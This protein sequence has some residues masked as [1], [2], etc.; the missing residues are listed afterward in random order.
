VPIYPLCTPEVHP[1]HDNLALITKCYQ[2]ILKTNKPSDVIFMGD[3]AGAC[4]AIVM[5][6]H[7]N[8]LKLPQPHHIVAISPVVD[9]TPTCDECMRMAKTD[10]ILTFALL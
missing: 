5:G 4:L 9:M 10:P 3:S 8:E 1:V 7:F 2:E 6:I